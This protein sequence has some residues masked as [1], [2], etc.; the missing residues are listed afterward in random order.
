MHQLYRFA[1][2]GLNESKV[3]ILMSAMKNQNIKNLAKQLNGTQAAIY[4]CIQHMYSKRLSAM[5]MI[6]K[7]GQ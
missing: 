6:Q 1:K 2:T 4:I 5:K 7:V 3:V